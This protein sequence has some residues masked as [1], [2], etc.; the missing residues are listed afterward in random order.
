MNRG[1]GCARLIASE[2]RPK[3]SGD[4]GE[5]RL[6]GVFN[7]FAFALLLTALYVLRFRGWQH[8]KWVAVYFVFFVILEAASSHYLLPPGAIGPELGYVCLGLTAPV[9]IA[10]YLVW[11]HEQRENETH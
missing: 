5:A 8:P 11:R 2:R 10:A 3:A 7:G 1:R 9:M 4:R 6:E